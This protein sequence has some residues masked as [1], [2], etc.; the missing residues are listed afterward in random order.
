[1]HSCSFLVDFMVSWTCT[2]VWK[3]NHLFEDVNPIVWSRLSSRDTF[4]ALQLKFGVSLPSADKMWPE[5]LH[6]CV[7]EV[8]CDWTTGR[9]INHVTFICLWPD[10]SLLQNPKVFGISSGFRE[11]WWIASDSTETAV[12][13]VMFTSV[14]LI[15]VFK[16]YML[17]L[18][19]PGKLINFHSAEDST[20]LLKKHVYNDNWV[21]HR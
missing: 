8:H 13:A 7:R 21:L 1:M 14:T 17:N 18:D 3:I 9:L 12:S 5:L 11:E 6:T 2:I 15:S 4:F 19:S 16:K 20:T 10:D